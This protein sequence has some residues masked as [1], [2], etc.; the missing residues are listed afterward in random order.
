MTTLIKQKKSEHKKLRLRDGA[1]EESWNNFLG[2]G[3]LFK[4]RKFNFFSY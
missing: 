2:I 4:H 1:S 3:M